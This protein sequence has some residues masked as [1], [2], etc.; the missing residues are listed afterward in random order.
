MTQLD[1]LDKTVL[2]GHLHL[3][4]LEP[5]E[6]LCRA[7]LKVVASDAGSTI[8]LGSLPLHVKVIAVPILQHGLARSTGDREGVLGDEAVNT[9]KTI[10]FTLSIGSANLNPVLLALSK[11]DHLALGL[12]SGNTSALHPVLSSSLG[13][14]HDVVGQRAAAVVLGSVPGHHAALGVDVV[15]PERTLR[16]V[17]S[18]LHHQLQTCLGHPV[19][20]LGPERE[21]AGVRALDVHRTRGLDFTTTPEPGLVSDRFSLNLHL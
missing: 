2:H 1:S 7:S 21:G 5:G 20:V 12:R 3:A 18:N 17:R 11:S 14:F 19:L 8:V 6:V 4:S 10:R 13:T 9:Y 16:L 15:D